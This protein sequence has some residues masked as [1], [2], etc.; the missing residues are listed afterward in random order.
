MGK[1][2]EATISK[3]RKVVKVE[4]FQCLKRKWSKWAQERIKFTICRDV[5]KVIRLK[6]EGKELK[7]EV[8]KST[9]QLVKRSMSGKDLMQ[10]INT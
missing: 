4:D 1:C 9:T 7:N 2:A 10:A 6:S 3:D 5:E 8:R